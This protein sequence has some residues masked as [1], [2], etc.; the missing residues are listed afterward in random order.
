MPKFNSKKSKKL[1]NNFSK[2]LA[3][4]LAVLNLFASNFNLVKAVKSVKA[5]K[6]DANKK[7]LKTDS[8]EN[9]FFPG[10]TESSIKEN[11]NRKTKNI[12]GAGVVAFLM[13]CSG[14]KIYDK[15]TEYISSKELLAFLK[16]DTP[17]SEDELSRAFQLWYNDFLKKVYILESEENLKAA[18]AKDLKDLI[19]LFLCSIFLVGEYLKI[20]L[21]GLEFSEFE[22]KSYTELRLG[23]FKAKVKNTEVT[24]N[25]DYDCYDLIENCQDVFPTAVGALGKLAPAFSHFTVALSAPILYFFPKAFGTTFELSSFFF[26]M[27]GYALKNGIFLDWNGW[28]L[29]VTSLNLKEFFALIFFGEELMEYLNNLKENLEKALDY[30]EKGPNKN[31]NVD[32]LS[33]L[34]QGFDGRKMGNFFNRRLIQ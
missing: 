17:K 19:Y 10:N 11:K 20:F 32:F 28:E 25:L 26:L 2:V 16:K 34:S 22:D 12:L 23:K 4:S 8:P 30:L 14:I 21:D 27:D 15:Y 6:G 3:A 18:S 31:P 9:S 13:A 1:K 7:T 29:D 33:S 5:V 24:V